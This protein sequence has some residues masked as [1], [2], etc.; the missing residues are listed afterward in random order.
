MRRYIAGGL[1]LC[2]LSL[3]HSPLG[4]ANRGYSFS[5]PA[6]KAQ[7]EG[8]RI[9]GPPPPERRQRLS[10]EGLALFLFVALRGLHGS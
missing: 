1:G 6:L 2:L 3:V 4:D 7:I 9:P 5:P 8:T 10:P